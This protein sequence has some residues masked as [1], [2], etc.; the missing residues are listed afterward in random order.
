MYLNMVL[1]TSDDHLQ[2]ILTAA[3]EDLNARVIRTSSGE[4][5]MQAV[6]NHRVLGLIVDCDEPDALDLLQSSA[7][8]ICRA[9]ILGAVVKDAAQAQAASE[10]GAALLLHRPV[11]LPLASKLARLAFGLVLKQYRKH[12]RWTVKSAAQIALPGGEPYIATVEDLGESGMR[13]S[14]HLPV[15]AGAQVDFRFVMPNAS[16]RRIQG[17]GKVAWVEGRNCGISFGDLSGSYSLW[18]QEWAT[19]RLNLQVAANARERSLFQITGVTEGAWHDLGH[20]HI[21]QLKGTYP[22]EHATNISA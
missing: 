9:G 20:K 22:I 8:K 1:Y 14:T 7:G 6:E 3:F 13:L 16:N 19:T 21:H 17:Q 18:I 12:M 4:K 11:L 2:R 10:N 5:A 15:T